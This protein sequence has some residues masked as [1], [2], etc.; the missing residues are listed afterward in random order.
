LVED[1]KYVVT[2]TSEQ[3]TQLLEQ[4]MIEYSNQNMGY[5]DVVK[6]C[7]KTVLIEL[8]RNNPY[9]IYGDENRA[10]ERRNIF[11]ISLNFIRN[12]IAL[13]ITATDVAESVN[14]SPRQLN[15]I[16]TSNI[17]MTVSEFIRNERILR[18]QEYLKKQI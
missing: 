11:D 1:D 13:N 17:D 16:F 6:F 14:L 18:V 12:N 2:Y 8:L 5:E 10:K 3:R 15:R 4:M 9:I 7:I